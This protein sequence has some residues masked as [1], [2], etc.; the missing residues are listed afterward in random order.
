MKK[1]CKKCKV[2]VITS[3]R[4]LTNCSVENQITANMIQFPVSDR[5]LLHPNNPLMSYGEKLKKI[6]HKIGLNIVH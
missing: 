5:L 6:E 3:L 1:V 2:L 4:S